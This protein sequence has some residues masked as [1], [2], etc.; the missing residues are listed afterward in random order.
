MVI[1][2]T[3]NTYVCIYIYTPYINRTIT[4]TII[5]MLCLLKFACR[6]WRLKVNA[7]LI[8]I[9]HAKGEW[10]HVLS[11]SVVMLDFRGKDFSRAFW[12]FCLCKVVLF[13]RISSWNF[14]GS[15]TCVPNFWE[16]TYSWF[17][18]C[19]FFPISYLR[20]DQLDR[21]RNPRSLIPLINY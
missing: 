21:W 5:L 17:S 16:K 19:S 18:N 9:C 8:N 4:I 12:Y 14:M 15:L 6:K 3:Y 11:G 7:T 20:T 10:P 13:S 2:I 1:T